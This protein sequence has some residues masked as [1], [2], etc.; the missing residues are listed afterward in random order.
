MRFP[1]MRCS[2]GCGALRSAQSLTPSLGP[3]VES[4][5]GSTFC[6]VGYRTFQQWATQSRE[7]GGPAQRAAQAGGEGRGE[8]DWRVEIISFSLLWWEGGRNTASS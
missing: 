1:K 8:G 2:R 4:G 3:E 7:A 5:S 6:S